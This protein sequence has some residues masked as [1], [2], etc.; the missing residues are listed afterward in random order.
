[1]LRLIPNRLLRAT[2]SAAPSLLVYAPPRVDRYTFLSQKYLLTVV[3]REIPYRAF[4]RKVD[5]DGVSAAVHN[6]IE[7]LYRR[8]VFPH[9]FNFF[10]K[11]GSL[12]ILYSDDLRRM[13]T[14]SVEIGSSSG[15]DSSRVFDIG[16]GFIIPETG[17]CLASN[18]ELVSSSIG[19]PEFSKKFTAESLARTDLE[20]CILTP[21]LFL[22]K[23]MEKLA[24]PI[25]GPLCALSPRYR[26][27]YHWMAETIPK[28]K[29]IRKYEEKTGENVTFLLPSGLPNWA[30]ESLS[31]LGYPSKKFI[32]ATE[33]IYMTDNLIIPPHPYPGTQEDYKWLR[34]QIFQAVP[35]EA[36]NKSTNIYI[37]RE[38]AISRRVVNEDAVMDVLSQN[39]FKKFIL[40]E[41][42]VRENISI[43][44]NANIIV[45]PHG[46]GLTDILFCRDAT[47]IELF[48]SRKND[49]YEQIAESLGFDYV[50]LDCEP[51]ANDI[52]VDVDEISS[53]IHTEH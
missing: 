34:K 43:F 12:R 52:R 47:I 33:S 49:A 13:A 45:S 48:G 11:R 21:R 35:I 6:S 23:N 9:L 29:Y 4:K 41:R 24:S 40:E 37:S 7:T 10:I 51:V 53:L 42:S 25:N 44:S 1:V 26:N 38:N 8:K 20:G 50:G 3:L 39:N 2:K 14:Q 28:L 16:S 18:L 15:V 17:L 5:Q 46:A 32:T 27:Y 22:S 19:S 31:L 36:S 30:S